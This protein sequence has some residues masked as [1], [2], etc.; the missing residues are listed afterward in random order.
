MPTKSPKKVGTPTQ[1]YRTCTCSAVLELCP[2]SLAPRSLTMPVTGPGGRHV[3]T[4][5]V[6][7]DP[8]A[9]MRWAVDNWAVLVLVWVALN[10]VFFIVLAKYR[11]PK[12]REELRVEQ[13]LSGRAAKLD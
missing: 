8:E 4:D 13:R 1:T 3:H 10:A 12:R 5:P 11:L 7:V 6:E 9:A 2:F